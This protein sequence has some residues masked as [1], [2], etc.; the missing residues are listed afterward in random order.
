MGDVM[1][2]RVVD[3]ASLIYK[4]YMDY[5]VRL[6]CLC[7]ENEDIKLSSQVS[8][9]LGHSWKRAEH[10]YGVER[11]STISL[12]MQFNVLSCWWKCSGRFSFFSGKEFRRV[13]MDEDLC[14]LLEPI[15]DDVVHKILKQRYFDQKFHVSLYHSHVLTHCT[16]HF[17]STFCVTV[18]GYTYYK[19][20]LS[21]P[22]HNLNTWEPEWVIAK[23]LG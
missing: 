12:L 4:P 19:V 10:C 22:E 21:S 18:C 15:T 23:L 16:N 14:Q 9:I 11:T 17:S 6:S 8:T 3:P 1:F 2:E 20:T 13:K 5:L 7:S